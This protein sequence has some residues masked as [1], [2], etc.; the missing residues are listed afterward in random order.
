MK[1]RRR[2]HPL[3]KAIFCLCRKERGLSCFIATMLL[4]SRKKA[5]IIAL[6]WLFNDQITAT[7]CRPGRK[8]EAATRPCAWGRFKLVRPANIPGEQKPAALHSRSTAI[9]TE[10]PPLKL[11]EDVCFLDLCSV[12]HVE[13]QNNPHDYVLNEFMWATFIFSDVI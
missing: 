3:C 6:V 5:L 13:T 8:P 12:P 11:F 2:P 10:P 7:I 9:C 1:T 4:M